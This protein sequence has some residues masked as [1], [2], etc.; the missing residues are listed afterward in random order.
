[1][2]YP[3]IHQSNQRPYHFL[4]GYHQYLEQKLS[5]SIPVS[6]F[7]GDVHL[8]E[9]EKQAPP[10]HAE[11]GIPEHF[12]IVIAGG[13]YDFTA[14]WWNP[15]SYQAVVDALSGRVAFVQCGE[16]GHWHPR[17]SGVIDLVGQTTLR[18][19]VQLIY[20]ADGVLCPVT[21]AM[22]LAA[23]VPTKRDRPRH[24]AAV[25]VAGGREPPHWEAYPAHQFLHTLGALPCCHHG[26]CWKSRC[27]TVGDGDLKDRY[28]LCQ[29]PVQ[30]SPELQIPK[31]MTM[32]TPQDVIRRIEL[33]YEGGAL[34]YQSPAARVAAPTTYQESAASDAAPTTNV[35]LRFR[36]GLGDAV[37]FTIVLKHLQKYRPHWQVD[38]TSLPGKHSAMAGL[39][40]CSYN[41][42]KARPDK[43]AYDQV[44][45]ID[46]HEA[47]T[48]SRQVPSTKV[49]R[50]LTETFRIMPDLSLYRYEIRRSEAA[51]A[52]AAHYLQRVSGERPLRHG[53]YPVML[54]HY[55]GNTSGGEKNLGHDQAREICQ[56]A[57][58][59]GLVPV[60]LDWDRRSPLPDQQDI[61]CPEV[62]AGDLWG[63]TGTGDAEML[64]ALIDQAFL[65]VGVDSGPVHVAGATNTPTLAVWTRHFA[66]QYYDLA[67]NV[68]HLVPRDWHTLGLRAIGP[69]PSSFKHTTASS[70]IAES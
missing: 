63:N 70:P 28:D 2:H 38:V 50:C 45:N 67:D 39:C 22:H 56:A 52:R 60:I 35:L 23:A 19:L 6:Q 21:L 8:S 34:T 47:A 61:F 9:E 11:K 1:M 30:V 24:R 3:L 33:Y 55:Q 44:Y 25:V 17:L 65:M 14:K 20:H 27:Q 66:G 43:S 15:Q 42:K 10:P 46:W 58:A 18:Q 37:Q 31:C 13:K 51:R 29:A 16:E 69:P 62:G 64:A 57:L 54:F 36:H 68:T 40:R 41:D 59:E 26:G 48:A 32:I 12:W 53:R 7:C 5:V 49:T 4:H